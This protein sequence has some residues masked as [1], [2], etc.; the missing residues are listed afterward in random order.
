MFQK[1]VLTEIQQVMKEINNMGGILFAHILYKNEIALFAVHQD[2]ACIRIMKGHDWH[3][4]P[5]IGIIESPTVT[6]NESAAGITYKHS[7][8]IKLPQTVFDSKTANDLR[9]NIIEG[10]I[11]CC[12]DPNGY[13]HIYG[14]GTYLLF[15]ELNKIIGKKVTDFTGYELK[16][17]GT[18]QYPVL[19]YHKV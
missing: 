13:K 3:I 16:L 8:T 5:T 11:L 14:T 7:V 1:C 18:S 9:N 2:T 6:P 17:S 12:Q 4:L 19:R 10:C 15:G